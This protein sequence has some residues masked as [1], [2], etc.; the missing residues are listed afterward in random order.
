MRHSRS[1]AMPSPAMPSARASPMSWS[2]RSVKRRLAP[3]HRRHGK[4]RP[5]GHRRNMAA[6][7]ARLLVAPPP[8]RAEPRARRDRQS[9]HIARRRPHHL[10]AQVDAGAQ[11]IGEPV[12]VGDLRGNARRGEPH[13]PLEGL[14]G[15]GVEVGHAGLHPEAPDA[16]VGE[17]VGPPAHRSPGGRLTGLLGDDGLVGDGLHPATTEHR[18]PH[19][20]RHQQ[21]LRAFDRR[22]DHPPRR[23]RGELRS[24]G[25]WSRREAGG[26]GRPSRSPRRPPPGSCG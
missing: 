18:G 25:R 24:G 5:R 7:A 12:G 13:V 9:S 26:P 2:S 8:L 3:G 1:V 15:E 6:R 11:V 4:I 21:P 16:P 14:R 20:P 10:V 19:A 17:A 22:R 23:A